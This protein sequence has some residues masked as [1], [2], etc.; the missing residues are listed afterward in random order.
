MLWAIDC[1][2]VFKFPRVCNCP[3]FV[4]GSDAQPK[5]F[6]IVESLKILDINS[7]KGKKSLS[8]PC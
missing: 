1:N 3:A 8:S 2:A 5:A 6:G 7:N 4:V